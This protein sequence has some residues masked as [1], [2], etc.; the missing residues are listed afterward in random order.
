MSARW[1]AEQHRAHPWMLPGL[2]ITASAAIGKG[3]V[4]LLSIMGWL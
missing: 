3:A 2:A 1:F 4:D